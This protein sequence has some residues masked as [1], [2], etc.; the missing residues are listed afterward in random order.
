MLTF[1]RVLP[2]LVRLC[3][4]DVDRAKVER[5]L[6][7]R[8]VRGRVRL[9]LKPV[10]KFANS[11][12]VALESRLRATL[13]GYLAG[14]VLAT[15]GGGDAARLANQLLSK[16]G[17][18]WPAGWPTN[19]TNLL[20][21]AATPLAIPAVWSG[22]ER[23]LSKDAWLSAAAPQ[24]PWPLKPGATPPIITFH[25]F[26]GGVGR[27]TL[28]AA[29]ALHLAKRGKKVALVDLD[30]EAPGLG[31]LFGVTTQRGVL[32]VLVDHLA[33]Q[34]MILVDAEAEP[35][36]DARLDANL[37]VFPAGRVDDAYLQKLARL[38]F[39]AEQP[40]GV[41]PVASALTDLLQ[42][43]KGSCD[44]ILLDSRAGL[45]DLA[46]ISL[47]GLAHVDVLVFR[48]SRQNLDG[49]AQTLRVLGRRHAGPGVA[50]ALVET[51]LP[52]R[53]EERAA[54]HERTR[55][56]VYDLLLEHVYPDDNPPQPG[57][58]GEPHDVLPVPRKDW[59]DALDV[60]DRRALD[61]FDRDDDLS[62]VC[63]RIDELAGWL[64]GQPEGAGDEEGE[65]SASPAQEK[66]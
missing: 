20:G 4:S 16:Y 33:T 25:S 36:V 37:R 54:V 7:V 49:L 62:S 26:K 27:T 21:A 23:A 39:S 64:D 29:Y 3:E 28:V 58:R 2:E 18:S 48:G 42:V 44:A 13:G 51:M 31:A 9:A 66:R 43:L 52:S 32:D 14:P 46:G 17:H 47:H 53:E 5:Y 41:N 50:M 38:D 19:Y 63:A 6:V 12:L 40:D 35:Q 22:V 45:H 10:K 60:L 11:D 57:D 8:D 24:R 1:D 55:S 59:L 61:S 34:Q 30:L 65:E 56:A 15:D